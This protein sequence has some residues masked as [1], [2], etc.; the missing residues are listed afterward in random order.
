MSINL[1][2]EQEEFKDFL[3]NEKLPQAIEG[4][5]T[6]IGVI[7]ET[8]L[9]L[10]EEDSLYETFQNYYLLIRNSYE[11][12]RRFI[13]GVHRNDDVS[14]SDY[15]GFI[16]HTGRLHNN[17]FAYL[18]SDP[19]RID[20][21]DFP[22]SIQSVDNDFEIKST[23]T[24]LVI[25]DWLVNG[26]GGSTPNVFTELVED[27]DPSDTEITI[28]EG[29]GIQAGDFCI[30]EG[31]G[32]FCLFT[33]VSVTNDNDNDILEV[34]Y[35]KDDFFSIDF[36]PTGTIE[37]DEDIVFTGLVWSNSE[38]SSQITANAPIA[39]NAILNYKRG[40]DSKRRDFIN[41]Q[42]IEINDNPNNSTDNDY[43]IAITQSFALI[44]EIILDDDFSN[45]ALSDWVD[46]YANREIEATDR[47]AE[48]ESKI[49]SFYDKI[50]SF[51]V[52]RYSKNQGTAY[53]LDKIDQIIGL[54][55]NKID[56]DENLI[57][58]LET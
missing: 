38:R 32:H 51:A 8:E 45:T 34:E 36:S 30:I 42:V 55:Q 23:D 24:R 47:V 52:V 21:F 27:I 1:T 57:S 11:G 4:N 41:F 40:F 14:N 10:T 20:A 3:Q 17:D 26:F 58:E 29:S 39:F 5:E 43:L 44:E 15:V 28:A 13:D 19:V 54:L 50:Y 33:V 35:Y 12:E 46:F 49:T 22:P 25:Y 2:P 53:V 9:E 6:S 56:R 16:G 7:Q 31:N 37:A 48:I 18:G